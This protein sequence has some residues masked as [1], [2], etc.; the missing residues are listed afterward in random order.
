M[1][2]LLRSKFSSVEEAFLTSI[3]G[4]PE[5]ESFAQFWSGL[6]STVA[7]G[8]KQQILDE[9]TLAEAH[10][11]ACRVNKMAELIIDLYEKSDTFTVSSQNDLAPLFADLS[12]DRQPIP[13]KP[14]KILMI[15]PVRFA[16]FYI[17]LFRSLLCCK[18]CRCLYHITPVYSLCFYLA[19]K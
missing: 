14:G 6:Q 7:E 8:V 9:E 1:S 4:P 10:V 17:S 16:D 12:V 15:Y 2:G 3:I 13:R 11:V 5:M 19:T 18:G